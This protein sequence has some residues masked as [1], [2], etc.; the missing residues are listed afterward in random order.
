MK[1]ILYYCGYC[2]DRIGCIQLERG[3]KAICLD[4]SE[5]SACKLFEYFKKS[6][7]LRKTML[8]GICLFCENRKYDH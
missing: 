6:R 2:F 3:K 5:E 4:C 7:Q 8:P 1:I